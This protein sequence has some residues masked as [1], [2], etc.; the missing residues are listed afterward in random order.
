M[1]PSVSFFLPLCPEL[2]FHILKDHCLMKYAII[3]LSPS[4]SKLSSLE[5]PKNMIS[6]FVSRITTSASGSLLSA[7]LIKKSPL[8]SEGVFAKLYCSQN[9]I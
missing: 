4:H 3:T 8:Q 2:P 6:D 5:V 1:S 9:E 7:L